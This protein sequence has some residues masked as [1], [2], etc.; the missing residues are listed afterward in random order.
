MTTEPTTICGSPHRPLNRARAASTAW[1]S[2]LSVERVCSQSGA[3]AMGSMIPDSR[4]SGREMACA[5]GASAS[6]LLVTSPSVYDRSEKVRPTRATMP[7]VRAAPTGSIFRP[8]GMATRISSVDWASRIVTSRSD[9][10]A[11]IAKR[12]I[13]VTRIRSTTP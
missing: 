3:S 6:S 8:N 9:R 7:S 10:P 4:S 5:M 1:V 11:S 12:L 13:G 2:G